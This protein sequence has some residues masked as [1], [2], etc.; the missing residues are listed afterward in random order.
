MVVAAVVAS[1]SNTAYEYV[2]AGGCWAAG[3]ILRLNALFRLGMKSAHESCSVFSLV[4]YFGFPLLRTIMVGR[5]I[6]IKCGCCDL[7]GPII[8]TA[9]E[10]KNGIF[11]IL[12]FELLFMVKWHLEKFKWLV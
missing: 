11:F 5:K 8:T 7:D 10:V 2:G 1:G 12:I 6:K 9:A 4:F 3:N